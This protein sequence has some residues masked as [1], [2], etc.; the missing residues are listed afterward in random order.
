[1]RF[2]VID[3]FPEYLNGYDTLPARVQCNWVYFFLVQI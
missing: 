2:S 3:L 1:M